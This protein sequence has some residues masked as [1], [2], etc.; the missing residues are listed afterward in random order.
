I[1]TRGANTYGPYQYPE[2]LIPY[3]VSEAL[4]NRKLSVYGDGLQQRDWL[5]VEDHCRAI[6]HVF[7]KG[8]PGEVYNV[9]GN[10]HKTNIEL[11]KSLLS[12]LGK[13]ASLIQFVADRKGH[14]RRYA[15]DGSK[16]KDLGFRHTKIFQEEFSKTLSW[17]ADNI[18][19]LNQ[20][21]QKNPEDQT[22]F[23]KQYSG[24]SISS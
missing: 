14:D 4:N 19:W 13:D 12:F 9:P 7:D 8:V 10:E 1:V 22:Y 2:K 5:H 6:L 23:S 24:R 15:M 21:R 18:E 20:I 11:T 17:Y 3:F 16:L